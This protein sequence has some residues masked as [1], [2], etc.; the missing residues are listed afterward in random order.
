M[1]NSI[2][3]NINNY[4]FKNCVDKSVFSM[5]T[6]GEGIKIFPNYKMIKLFINYIIIP[7]QHL[8]IGYKNNVSFLCIGNED[9]KILL[10]ISCDWC[11]ICNGALETIK[12]NLKQNPDL[13]NCVTNWKKVI[14]INEYL[15]WVL[16]DRVNNVDIEDIL[17]FSQSNFGISDDVRFLLISSMYL[18]FEEIELKWCPFKRSKEYYYRNY[19]SRYLVPSMYNIYKVGE[20][21]AKEEKITC[22]N[23]PNVVNNSWPKYRDQ[24]QS[25]FQPLLEYSCNLLQKINDPYDINVPVYI[26]L[27]KKLNGYIEFLML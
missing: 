14:K 7:F 22:N 8:L 20:I 17:Q 19:D 1:L 2:A 25:V 11:S 3:L 4:Y 26:D 12:N 16:K 15:N 27:G 24:K 9:D 13:I 18:K 6:C 21:L 5:P 23:C 10:T